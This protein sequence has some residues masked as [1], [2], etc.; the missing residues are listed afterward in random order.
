VPAATPKE[1]SAK[2][3]TKSFQISQT[4]QLLNSLSL[5][6]S[7]SLIRIPNPSWIRTLSRFQTSIEDEE[8]QPIRAKTKNKRSPKSTHMDHMT[9][10]FLTAPK[11]LGN[12]F[13]PK[14]PFLFLSFQAQKRIRVQNNT[15]LP[16]SK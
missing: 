5:S 10:L 12:F 8:N 15:Y 11:N 16:I 3:T 13:V 9:M 2:D 4:T 14:H 1:N 6:L 7:L